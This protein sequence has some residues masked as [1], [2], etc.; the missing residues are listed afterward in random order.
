[1]SSAIKEKVAE[2]VDKEI[3]NFIDKAASIKGIIKSK[4]NY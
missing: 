4:M 1:M 2:P 3:S